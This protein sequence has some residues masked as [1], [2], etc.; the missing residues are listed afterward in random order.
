M[1]SRLWDSYCPTNP[2]PTL[3]WPNASGGT[4]NN[5]NDLKSVVDQIHS[6]SPGQGIVLPVY[7]D[8]V[9]AQ[10]NTGYFNT[11]GVLLADAA[12][13]AM[14]ALHLELESG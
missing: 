12:I 1:L 4:Q 7:M 11:P 13:F 5:Y 3:C 10:N 9:Y 8:E 14:G 2:S 6:A